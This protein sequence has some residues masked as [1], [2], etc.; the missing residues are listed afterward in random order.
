IAN[1]GA[2]EFPRLRVGIRRQLPPG[3]LTEYV[4]QRFSEEER[5]GLKA[6]VENA[7]SAIEMAVTGSLEKAMTEFN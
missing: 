4:L 6:V 3:D 7:C 2:D 1:L 5:S